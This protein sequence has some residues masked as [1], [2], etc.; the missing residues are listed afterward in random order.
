MIDGHDD[1]IDIDEIAPDPEDSAREA[2][3]RYVHDDE[4]GIARRRRGKG[5][6]YRMPD[7][8][9]VSDA[10]RKRIDA[11]AIPPA[12]RDVWI[13]PRANGHIQA[14]GRDEA[15][16]KQYVY[17]ERWHEVRD[18]AKYHRMIAFGEAL[19]AIRA[20]VDADMRRA[21]LSRDYILALVLSILDAT[22][23]RVGN[24]EYAKENG[25][26]GLTTLRKRHVEVIGSHLHLEFV[27]KSG[28]E[29]TL[30]ITNRR[31]ARGI[32]M[33]EELPGYRLFTYL[34]EKGERHRIDSDDVNDYLHAIAG[35]GFTAKDF[36]TWRGTV[37]AAH[38]LS[39]LTSDD[40][41]ADTKRVIVEVVK[42][43][44]AELGN[45]PAV[46]RKHYIHPEVLAAFT[47]GSTG[48]VLKGAGRAKASLK[49]WLSPEELGLL[50]FLKECEA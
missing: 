44:A 31:L 40:S 26:F 15:G 24:D 22:G 6:T 33:C 5:F 50:A 46:C 2:G 4:P 18:A 48:G 27:G 34:D 20:R 32:R 13:A 35:D 29:Q 23:I 3:L 14:T 12:W 38:R 45:T 11:L 10:V 47:D 30:D 1:T 19:P 37:L 28:V 36:R 42:E 17:H 49:K 7:G 41:E 9:N 16:R 21:D 39:E 8:T 25:T 43:V